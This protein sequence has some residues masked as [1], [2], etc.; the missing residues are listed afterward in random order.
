[1]IKL[2]FNYSLVKLHSKFGYYL[3][4]KCVLITSG[5]YTRVKILAGEE[6]RRIRHQLITGPPARI[7]LMLC[8]AGISTSQS[9]SDMQVT[10]F[11]QMFAA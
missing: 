11:S 3:K 9:C 4:G 1:M 6:L 2:Y 5:N 8:N 10:N 7:E